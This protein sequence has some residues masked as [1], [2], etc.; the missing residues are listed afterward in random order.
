[1]KRPEHEF[2]VLITPSRK[3]FPIRHD[4][5]IGQLWPSWTKITRLASCDT[6]HKELLESLPIVDFDFRSAFTYIRQRCV[7]NQRT[8]KRWQSKSM[9]RRWW[10]KNVGLIHDEGLP[11]KN[12]DRFSDPI[13]CD[14]QWLIDDDHDSPHLRRRWG[15]KQ[16]MVFWP[17]ILH[18]EKCCS[19]AN[20]ALLGQSCGKPINEKHRL[21][22]R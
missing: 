9:D 6:D 2:I 7:I 22:R 4:F 8:V 5:C 20:I 21:R 14:H 3:P 11:A 1:M 12:F 18:I 10:L 19:W 13:H 16:S 15:M 17:L